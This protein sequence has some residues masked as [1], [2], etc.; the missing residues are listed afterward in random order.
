MYSITCTPERKQ[1][2]TSPSYHYSSPESDSPYTPPMTNTGLGIFEMSHTSPMPDEIQTTTADVWRHTSQGFMS[3]TILCGDEEQVWARLQSSTLQPA[4][5]LSM[6]YLT[7]MPMYN[8]MMATS[9]APSNSAPSFALPPNHMNYHGLGISPA[10]TPTSRSMTPSVCSLEDQ[11]PLLEASYTS[12][13]PPNSYFHYS[14]SHGGLEITMPAESAPVPTEY[15]SMQPPHHA[16]GSL[17]NEL[18]Q[19]I[20]PEDTEAAHEPR[21]R[22]SSVAETVITP[23]PRHKDIDKSMAKKLK[24]TRKRNSAKPTIGDPPRCDICERNFSRKHNLQQH[25]ERKH[26]NNPVKIHQ[27]NHC[28]LA[29]ARLTDLERHNISVRHIDSPRRSLITTTE[30]FIRTSI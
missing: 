26:N 13:E 2:D 6:D 9:L 16:F 7:T 5:T 15:E 21:T 25:V 19:D 11:K 12:I 14:N 24:R 1:V 28:E 3:S 23:E 22:Q 30:T 8:S 18:N 27:C 20:L 29:F 17:S 10:H 4:T